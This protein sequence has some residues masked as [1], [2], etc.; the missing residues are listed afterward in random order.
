[1]IAKL[2]VFIIFVFE[3]I[4]NKIVISNDPEMEYMLIYMIIS[5]LFVACVAQ[6]S[7]MYFYQS[8]TAIIKGIIKNS[9][10]NYYI[11]I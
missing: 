4:C 11:S 5:Y 10:N 1:M 2:C 8:G 3:I 7:N 9:K 6:V